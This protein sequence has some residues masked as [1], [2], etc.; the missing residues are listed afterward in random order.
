M[1]CPKCELEI[2]GEDQ[3]NCPICDS[4]LSESLSESQE[5]QT[6]ADELVLNDMQTTEP[7]QTDGKEPSDDTALNLQVQ[8]DENIEDDLKLDFDEDSASVEIDADEQDIF[9]LEEES[10]DD[11]SGEQ[12]LTLKTDEVPDEAPAPESDTFKLDEEPGDD[13]SGEQPLTLE[14][15]EAPETDP[16]KFEEPAPPSQEQPQEMKP[17]DADQVFDLDLTREEGIAEPSPED[18]ADFKT[19]Q[20]PESAFSV[21]KPSTPDSSAEE[22]ST[23]D[24]EDTPVQEPKIPEDDL[25]ETADAVDIDTMDEFQTDSEPEEATTLADID[26]LAGMPVEEPQKPAAG[27]R[28]L[29]IVLIFIFGA[30]IGFGALYYFAD[31]EPP[32]PMI[33][34]KPPE[35]K[36]EPIPE[37]E[38]DKTE[39]VEKPA[40]DVIKPEEVVEPVTPEPEEKKVKVETL[41]EVITAPEKPEP[42]VTVTPDPRPEPEPK[43]TYSVHAGSYRS[44]DRANAEVRRFSNQGFN[45]YIE[46]ADLGEKGIWYRVKIG[47][48][49]SREEAQKEQEALTRRIKGV[50]SRVVRN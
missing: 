18:A 20:A 12:P 32:P 40:P 42:P 16:F 30:A 34:E 41:P 26:P 3:K 39:P 14:T 29:F 6:D 31:K 21:D 19:D 36:P 38:P 10:G 37:P 24:F 45:A 2:K 27:R 15:D 13:L 43:T 33:A 50:E 1:F 25:A 9:K 35:I 23:E 5:S 22:P 47:M 4:E 7:E 49:G 46:R 44:S 11:L 48:F 8:G 28:V 17:D